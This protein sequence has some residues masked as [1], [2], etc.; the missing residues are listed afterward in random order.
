MDLFVERELL[1]PFI[2]TVA[3]VSIYLDGEGDGMILLERTQN[4][5]WQNT[6]MGWGACTTSLAGWSQEMGFGSWVLLAPENVW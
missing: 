5:R 3:R 1:R 6:G 2:G 4:G